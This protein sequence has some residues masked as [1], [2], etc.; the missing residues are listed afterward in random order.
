MDRIWIFEPVRRRRRESGLVVV[1]VRPAARRSSV[2]SLAY[3]AAETGTGV[4]VSDELVWLGEA[5]PELLPQVAQGVARRAAG[6]GSGRRLPFREFR[7]DGS[8]ERY[9]ELVAGVGP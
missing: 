3:T 1:N 4:E 7:V 2:L 6:R 8:E 9:S 5:E